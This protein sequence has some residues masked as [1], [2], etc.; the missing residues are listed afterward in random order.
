MATNQETIVD[1][2]DEQSSDAPVIASE[3]PVSVPTP[4]EVKTYTEL[5]RGRKKCP[6]CSLIVGAKQ[7]VCSCG[8]VFVKGETSKHP[9][10]PKPLKTHEAPAPKIDKN[11]VYRVLRGKGYELQV[12][13]DIL[14]PDSKPTITSEKAIEPLLNLIN[15]DEIELIQSSPSIKFTVS[16]EGLMNVLKIKPNK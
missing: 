11:A 13:Q 5:G 6:S 3:S 8:H 9:G 14:D 16:L 1:L 12:V 10:T 15:S 4:S 2:S 7:A